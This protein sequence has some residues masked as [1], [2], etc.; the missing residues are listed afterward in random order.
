MGQS[1]YET[2]GSLAKQKIPH[3][4]RNPISSLCLFSPATCP[5]PEHKESIPCN[6]KFMIIILSSV[7]FLSFTFAHQN[8]FIL[9]MPHAPPISSVLILV[10][11]II[12]GKEYRSWIYSFCSCVRPPVISYL[13]ASTACIL[14][15]MYDTK[16]YTHIREQVGL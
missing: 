6:P 13:V 2:T 12:F 9:Y 11:L 4:L 14:P 3:I 16:F 1:P 5:Y 8:P 10:T 15:L 7:W